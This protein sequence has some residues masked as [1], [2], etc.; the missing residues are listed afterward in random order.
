M[1][2][3]LWLD[4]QPD[5]RVDVAQS[6][7]ADGVEVSLVWTEEDAIRHL[8]S[9]SLPDVF[10]QDLSRQRS[11]AQATGLPVRTLADS[12][13]VSGWAF[14]REVLLPAFPQLPVIIVTWDAEGPGNRRKADDFNLTLLPKGGPL[15]SS[16]LAAIARVRDAQRTILVGGANAPAIVAVDFEKVSAGLVRHLA[17]TP[18]DLDRISPRA[19]EE[20]VE[21]ILKELGYEVRRTKLTRDGGVDLWALQRS[22][23]G[24]TL[25]AIDAK[26]YNRRH[27]IG[28]EPVRAIYG[29]TNFENASAGMIV[30]TATFG[31]AARQLANQ[32][33]Y[34]VSLKDCDD[35]MA[36][37][38]AVGGHGAA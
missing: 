38:N 5:L 37:I 4:D 6:L 19:F 30:T 11:T 34:R 20:L 9:E 21:V 33:R 12:S 26:K 25:Y 3:V 31:P 16:L 28:P 24:D 2:R 18:T 17:R 22:D 13:E 10:V 35:L 8:E 14:Y 27:V 29:V 7:K 15:R 32:Y 36:W 1:T 23:L